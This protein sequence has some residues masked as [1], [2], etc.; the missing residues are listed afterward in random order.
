MK[1]GERLLVTS[2]SYADFGIHGYFRA[3]R[4][5]SWREEVGSFREAVVGPDGA[6][7]TH[8]FVANLISRGLIEEVPLLRIHAGDGGFIDPAAEDDAEGRS[9]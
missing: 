3:L 2:G 7:G 1:A 8:Q 6:R 4:D 9:T 5:F